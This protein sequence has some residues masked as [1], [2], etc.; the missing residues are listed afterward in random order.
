MNN[1]SVSI[2]SPIGYTGYGVVGW[3]I[4]KMLNQIGI[5]TTVFPINIQRFSGAQQM[6]SESDTLLLDKLI[7]K[8]CNKKATCIK[9]WH[10]FDMAER[11]GCGKYI[12]FPFFELTK[13][14]P[15]EKNHLSIPDEL[16]V[17]SEWAKKVILDNGI[18]QAVSVVPL[19]VDPNI[20]TLKSYEYKDSEPYVFLSVGK[21]EIRKGHD[22]LYEIFN[23]TFRPEDNVELWI[24]ASSSLQ[25]FSQKELTEWHEYYQSG[26]LK[27][28][29]KII[30]R[31]PK[32]SDVSELMNKANCGIF[33]S[34]AEGWNLELLEMMSLG[35]PVITTNYSAHTEFCNKDN[36]YLIDIDELEPAFDGKWFHGFGEWAKIGDKQKKQAIEYMRYVYEN[37]I[38]QNITG[39]ETGQKYTWKNSCEKII[40]C[41]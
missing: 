7:N 11:I 31:L 36:A 17:S 9:V 18:N 33:M 25:C 13:F 21:W 38:T 29:I 27:D 26:P 5:D 28:K 32:Q 6:D 19:G 20:F 8:P 10:Q 1:K 15:R 22:I 14:N 4:A 24:C 23:N 41:I 37:K 34:R 35:K 40:Q 2:Y 12:G 39:I 30:S 16:V 3:N